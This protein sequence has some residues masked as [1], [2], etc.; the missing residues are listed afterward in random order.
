MSTFLYPYTKLCTGEKGPVQMAARP[1]AWVC[2]HSPA[3]ISG[4]NLPGGGMDVTCFICCQVSASGWSLVQRSLTE[5]GVS[6]CDHESLT[7]R[8]PWPT[9]G[10]CAVVKKD[11]NTLCIRAWM[12]RRAVLDVSEN[13]KKCFASTMIRTHACPACDIFTYRVYY[14]RVMFSLTEYITRVWYFHLPSILPACDIVTYRVHYQSVILSLTEYITRVWY[15]NLASTLPECDI[16]TYRVHYQSVILS[17]TEYITRV[18][19]CH[20]PSTLSAYDIITY[21]VHYQ[22]VI[23]SLTE[24]ITSAP[25]I[26]RES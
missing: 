8:R 7:M 13:R 4:S 12:G 14:Q 18:W 15:C 22:S 20:L 11:P 24:Y 5:C 16:L 9:E 25:R 2:G 26:R 3:G 6:E 17:L 10:C 23:L 19:Y 1:K 21:R